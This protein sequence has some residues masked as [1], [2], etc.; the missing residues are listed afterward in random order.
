[1]SGGVDDPRSSRTLDSA[2]FRAAIALS[3]SSSLPGNNTLTFQIRGPD[4]G[5]S[6]EIFRK[7]FRLTKRSPFKERGNQRL[8]AAPESRVDVNVDVARFLCKEQ[9]NK[10]AL[11][12]SATSSL[13]TRESASS[14]RMSWSQ[15]TKALKASQ[16]EQQRRRSE[17]HETLLCFARS[18]SC[19][20]CKLC[21]M[22]SC[23]LSSSIETDCR[24][25]C[26]DQHTLSH[27]FILQPQAFPRRTH[28]VPAG[29]PGAIEGRYRNYLPAAGV[30]VPP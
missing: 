14:W 29:R 26:Q 3:S 21:A 18:S 27:T 16:Q 20:C 23:I 7:C 17:H 19:C 11:P 2:R 5:K 1:M 8:V 28:E 25:S 13:R 24:S 6:I 4:T 9:Y 12:R 30:R 15:H 10:R 22:T